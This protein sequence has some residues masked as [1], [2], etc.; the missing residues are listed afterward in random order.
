MSVC[1]F[2]PA[3]ASSSACNFNPTKALL[4]DSVTSIMDYDDIPSLAPTITATTKTGKFSSRGY[5]IETCGHYYQDATEFLP[6]LEPVRG[7]NNR[8]LKKQPRIQK[9]PMTWWRAQCIFRGL[10]ATGRGI[11]PLQARLRAVPNAPMTKELKELEAKMDEGYAEKNIAAYEKMVNKKKAVLD[12]KWPRM[13]AEEKVE[14]DDGYRF[15]REEFPEGKH[16]GKTITVKTHGLSLLLDTARRLGLKSDTLDLPSGHPEREGK[17]DSLVIISRS[18]SNFKDNAKWTKITKELKR[19]KKEAEHGASQNIMMATGKGLNWNVT[20]TYKIT[21]P[22]LEEGYDT[23]GDLTLEIFG[24]QTQKG[25]Q[26]FA[27][28]DFGIIEG[29]MRFERQEGGSTS[30]SGN[31]S[32]SRS[33]GKKRKRE[34]DSEGEQETEDDA[35]EDEDEDDE[36]ESDEYDEDRRSPTPESFYLGAVTMPS[37]KHPTWDYRW[38]GSETGEGEIQLGS[39]ANQYEITFCEP[40][41]TKIKGMFGSEYHRDCGFT[42]VKIAPGGPSS[43]DISQEWADR[44]SDAH[45]AA[46]VGRWH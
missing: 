7:K 25:P 6:L 17:F 28:F 22:V 31:G 16:A 10:D 35:S 26:L 4:T 36:E 39:D 33:T 41:G 34:E 14:V 20:G 45:E 8:I 37:K 44:N 29:V 42:G 3:A 18:S 5:G 12:D 32:G 2:L 24:Q 40:R 30:S 1:S 9:Q 23:S 13:T 43:I 21:C 27:Q 15:L 19:A 38:R 11:E 46:R